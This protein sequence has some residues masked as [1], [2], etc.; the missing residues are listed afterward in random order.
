MA[1]LFGGLLDSFMLALEAEGKS[2]K[3]LDNYSRAVVAFAQHLREQ[4]LSTDAAPYAV[5]DRSQCRD[6]DPPYGEAYCPAGSE[7]GSGSNGGSITDVFTI[8]DVFCGRCL[9]FCSRRD[10]G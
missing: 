4:G 2:P 9:R 10:S 6:I 1:E 3:T 5:N 8:T 7:R